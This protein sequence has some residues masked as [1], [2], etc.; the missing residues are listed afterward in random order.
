MCSFR[1][2]SFFVLILCLIAAGGV[3]AQNYKIRQT[4]TMNGQQSES[5]VYVKGSRKRTEGG[6]FMGMGGDVATVEQCD[7]RRD[8]KISDKKKMYAIEPY[9]DGSETP[10]AAPSKP[11]VG[12]KTPTVKGGTVTYISN[13]TDT[14]ERKQMFGMTARHI[15]T[16]MTMEASPD[17]CMKSDMKVETD[18]WY[19][20]LPEF[21]CPMTSRPQTTQMPRGATGGGC[22][23]RIVFKTTGGGKLGFA[24]QETRTFASGGMSF[25]QTTETLEFSKATLDP[26]LF[27]IPAG[28]ALTGDANDLYGRPDYAAM[29]KTAGQTEPGKPTIGTPIMT[30]NAKKPGVI[31]IGV[32][33]PTNRSGEN[34]STTNLQTFLIGRLTAGKIEAVAVGTEADA[35]AAQCDY[36]LSSDFSKLKQSTASKIGGIFGKVTNTDTS[37]TRN[38]DAQVDFKLVPLAGG[39]T[40]SDK[41]ANKTEGDVDRAAE[42]VLA[43]EAQQILGAIGR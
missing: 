16:S 6:G 40:I 23:D 11:T 20:D 7:L 34:V 32:Y 19:I 38:Y 35:R 13:V 8:V 18:G 39:K 4:V 29:A 43:L 14:G 21:S 12:A 3:S 25:T 42:A 15:R 10:P 30:T 26:A 28:Y 41:A 17:A 36:V 33:A 9:D 31:R 5:T 22:R 27:E 24:L 2:K 37:A 1:Q